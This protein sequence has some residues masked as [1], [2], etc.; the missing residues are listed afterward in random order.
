MIIRDDVKNRLDT[1][2][3]QAWAAAAQTVE[4]MWNEPTQ[5]PAAVTFGWFGEIRGSLEVAALRRGSPPINDTWTQDLIFGC[6]IPGNADTKAG[7][8]AVVAAVSTVIDMIVANPHLDDQTGT[9]PCIAVATPTDLDGP[10]PWRGTNGAGAAC[11]LQLSFTART[12][13]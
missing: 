6:W 10:T 1:L 13:N 4:W 7:E 5:L 11:R 2:M 3:P 9:P 12:H 8:N